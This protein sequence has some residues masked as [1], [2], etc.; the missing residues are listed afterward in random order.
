[1]VTGTA[2]DVVGVD[3]D[4]A[5]I[6][7]GDDV[8]LDVANGSTDVV[9]REVYYAAGTVRDVVRYTREQARAAMVETGHY[10][11]W[12]NL[13]ITGELAEVEGLDRAIKLLEAASK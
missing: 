5:W 12:P 3:Y 10:G 9:R 8:V 13:A 4:H 11:P 2:G 1:M 6:E 7:L